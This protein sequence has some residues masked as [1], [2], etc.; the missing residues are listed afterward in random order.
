[1][2]S[3]LYIFGHHCGTHKNL[4]STL[5][6][7]PF[8]RLIYSAI[9]PLFNQTDVILSIITIMEKRFVFP[10]SELEFDDF[11]LEYSFGCTSFP[12]AYISFWDRTF[13]GGGEHE[14]FSSLLLRLRMTGVVVIVSCLSD[15]FLTLELT[16]E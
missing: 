1:M 14:M 7:R 2:T 10:P 13:E 9:G 15:R 3:H 16:L 6:L 4:V 5:T 11:D 8:K 12:Y